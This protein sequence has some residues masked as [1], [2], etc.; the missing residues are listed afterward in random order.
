MKKMLNLKRV[1]LVTGML[2]LAASPALAAEMSSAISGVYAT[3]SA[4]VAQLADYDTTYSFTSDKSNNEFDLG[5]AASGAVGY[6]FGNNFRLE[7]EIGYQQSDGDNQTFM[8]ITHDTSSAE[9]N[10]WS[11]LANAYYDFTNSSPFTPYVSAGLGLAKIEVSNAEDDDGVPVAQFGAGVGYAVSKQVT[12][13]L[14]YRYIISLSDPEFE[15]S[16]PSLSYT[17]EAEVA[18]HNV[19]LGVRVGL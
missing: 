12:L 18:S 6:G 16:S 15:F 9:I 4:G 1:L 2:S 14:K 17:A 3:A 19:L 10:M 13:D 11:F 5:W 7:G 8:G